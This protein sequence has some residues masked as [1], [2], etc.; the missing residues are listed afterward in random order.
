MNTI[1]TS[2]QLLALVSADGSVSE[3]VTIAGGCWLSGLTGVTSLAGATLAER[4]WLSGLTGVTS[5]AGV[6][7][8][9]RCGLSG[10]TGQA[11]KDYESRR[12]NKWLSTRRG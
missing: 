1:R 3:P 6:T 5:L 2:E 7:L 12:R 11:R 4:C 10:L 9:E 8:A